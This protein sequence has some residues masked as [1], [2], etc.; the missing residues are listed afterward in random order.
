MAYRSNMNRMHR[1]ARRLPAPLKAVVKS[2]RHAVDPVAVTL[3]RRRT[4]DQ[5]A[6]P[7]SAI[8]ARA[9]IPEIAKWLQGGV[10][11]AEQIDAVLEHVDARIADFDSVLDFGSGGGRVLRFVIGRGSKDARFTGSDVDAKAIAWAREH[12]PRANWNVNSY[13]P[14]LT[15]PDAEFDLV[16]SVSIFSH[17]NEALQFDW[18]KEIARVT[19]PGGYAL[20]SVH[21]EHAYGRCRTGDVVSNSS[22]CARRVASHGDLDTE[23]FIYEPYEMGNWTKRDFPGIDAT[24]GMTFHS[25]AYIRNKWTSADWEVVDVL[26]RALGNWQ[27]VALLRRR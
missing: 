10:S 25:P 9:G 11:T 8:R 3:Y 14:P 21:G 26:P 24:F 18:L 13:S 20:L 15:F 7:P 27:D 12:H 5:Q 2:G 22:S 17:L 1:L 16:Y 19:R 23:G 6:I 4:G